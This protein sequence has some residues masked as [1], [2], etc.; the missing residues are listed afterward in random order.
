MWRKAA[1]KGLRK[2]YYLQ[3]KIELQTFFDDICCGG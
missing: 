1:M 2:G 3:K